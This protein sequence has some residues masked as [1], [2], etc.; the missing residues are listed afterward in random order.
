MF[1]DVKPNFNTL[2]KKIGKNMPLVVKGLKVMDGAELAA[3]V[4]A[5]QS[6]SIAGIDVAPEDLQV[7]VNEKEG[8]VAVEDKGYVAILDVNI[9]QELE[10][11]GMVR[12]LVR[13]IQTLRKEADFNVDDR[14]GLYLEASKE[15]MAAVSAHL[16]YLETETLASLHE[17]PVNTYDASKEIK[18][19]KDQII[20]NIIRVK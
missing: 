5:G 4:Q 11:E 1:Y 19:G 7:T 13:H 18:V 17:N 20:I 2:G 3:K 14:I 10:Q 9:T 16:Q 12:D 15:L 6:V 8:V